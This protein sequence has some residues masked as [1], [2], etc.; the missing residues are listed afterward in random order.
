M[1]S[2][3]FV[4]VI[5]P[6]IGKKQQPDIFL[7]QGI[8]KKQEPDIFLF[9]GIRKKQEPDIFLFQG[10]GNKQEP[11]ISLFQGIGNKQEPDI[12]LKH[13]VRN[14]Q[15][16]DISLKHGVR[17][18]QEP[19]ISLKHGVRNRQE[20]DISLKHG[21]RNRQQTKEK[22]SLTQ[23]KTQNSYGARLLI[24][25]KF[26]IPT[27]S[28]R[29]SYRCTNKGSSPF[30]FKSSLIGWLLA[31]YFPVISILP[32]HPA[33]A[34]GSDV[35]QIQ[36][37]EKL[38]IPV[39]TGVTIT[40]IPSQQIIQKIW[41]DN[42]TWITLDI[43]GCLEGLGTSECK[44]SGAT[45]IHLRR[46]KPLH[47]EG[48]LPSSTS[49]LTVISRDASESLTISTFRLVAA[50]TDKYSIV[51]VVLPEGKFVDTVNPDFVARGRAIAILHGWMR[52]GDRLYQK[53]DQFLTLITT[54]PLSVA[55]EESGV[56]IALIQRLNSLGSRE[57]GVGS[58]E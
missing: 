41:L 27:V 30:P 31:I 52:S 21:V 19:D 11:D 16:S 2:S 12:S 14:R 40:F 48:I 8:G 13:G 54:H 9:Q 45:S 10:I 39:A 47:I 29:T 17:N 53:I 56:S 15:E 42:P 22:N 55:A 34:T 4:E 58:R 49:L 25:K 38:D 46:I 1:K 50:E 51:E 26:R 33:I 44:K 20:P 24:R 28:K 37:G 18:K 32:Q 3:T 5:E 57:W 35:T 43:D 36:L 23:F 7:F 6:E